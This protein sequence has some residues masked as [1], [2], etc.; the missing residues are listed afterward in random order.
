MPRY[1]TQFAYTPEAWAALARS[2]EDRREAMDRL[3][4]QLGARLIDLY[5]SFGDYDGLLIT[6]APDD[7]TQA[8]VVLAAIGP[9]HVK[10][11]KTTP[12]LTVEQLI[13]TL[14]RVGGIA[15]RAPGESNT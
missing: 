1:M 9:G 4:E 11:V 7:M 8:A 15:Y 6:E 2:P 3:C 13:E 10:A 5:Y 14:R 12:L